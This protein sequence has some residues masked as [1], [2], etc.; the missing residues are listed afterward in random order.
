MDLPPMPD[1]TPSS[2]LSLTLV[3]LLPPA[4]ALLSAIALW[5][6]A[7]ARS[8]SKD[9]LSTSEAAVQLSLLPREPPARSAYRTGVP[10]RRKS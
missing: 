5:V 1:C 7:K 2:S 6:G 9:A 10:D 3:Y 8:I 4:G